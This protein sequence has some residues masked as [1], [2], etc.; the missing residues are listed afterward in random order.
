MVKV[1]TRARPALIT[2]A[3]IMPLLFQASCRQ[4]VSPMDS[5]APGSSVTE[6]TATPKR[7][8][9]PVPYSPLPEEPVPEVK[10]L[11]ADA[12]Q[13]IG[14]YEAG[15]GTVDLA[16]G[17]LAGRADAG[18][19]E[20]ATPMLI[21]TAASA[22]DIIYPQLSGLTQTEAGIMAVFRQRLL[23]NGNERSVTRTA[24]LRFRR[25][26]TGWAISQMAPLGGEPK[27]RQPLSVAAEAV[28]VH[29]RIRLPDSARWDIEAG[30]VD[31]RVLNL[32]L[33]LAAEHALDVTVFASG[34]PHNVFAS[35]SVSNHTVGRAVDIWAVNSEEVVSQRDDTGPLHA[36]VSS[37][38]A[39]GVTELGSPWDLDGAGSGAS[40][41]NTV[42][43]DHLHLAF[44][45]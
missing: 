11:A 9:D 25:T 44:D 17:R 12:L 24:D 35:R 15:E 31:E 32:L 3:V 23:E 33:D 10:Q 4:G 19:V 2:L 28:L 45:D 38:L 13:A 29:D 30:T 21:P 39:K 5:T 27:E 14:T 20:A 36:L 42:H 7:L 6:T 34:H 43:Q 16:V 37:L 26:S 40:F 41:T 22:V 8:A 1:T 18:V